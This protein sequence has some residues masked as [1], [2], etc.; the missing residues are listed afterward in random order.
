M[1]LTRFWAPR[2]GLLLLLVMVWCWGAIATPA[3]ASG[4]DNYVIQYLKATEAIELPLN[5]R[6]DTRA[7]TPED[8]TRGKRLFEENCKNCHVGGTTLPNPLVSLSLKDLKGAVPPRDTIA[9]LVAF[10]RL[11]MAY[12]GSEESYW[13]RQVSEDWL[14][15]NQLEDLAAFILRAAAV[16]PG[17][18]TE[19]FPDSAP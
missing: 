7:F 15:T 9:S 12:D 10:Q 13:C 16:A 1:H 11:P 17:W 8:L 6:G 19:T 18:G 3:A 4:V 5:D 2:L 14:T